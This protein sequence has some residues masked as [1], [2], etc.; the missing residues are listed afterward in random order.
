MTLEQT[1]EYKDK[2]LDWFKVNLPKDYKQ[3]HFDAIRTE[4]QTIPA[5]KQKA[6]LQSKDIYPENGMTL[7]EGI[8]AERQASYLAEEVTVDMNS[9]VFQIQPAALAYMLTKLNILK[10]V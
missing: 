1:G 5:D 2:L 4:L 7:E 3:A 9:P 6:F 10:R 8:E